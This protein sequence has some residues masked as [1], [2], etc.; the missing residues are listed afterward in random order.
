MPETA[1][2]PPSEFEVQTGVPA[3]RD[4]MAE[5]LGQPGLP[6]RMCYHNLQN[7]IWPGVHRGGKWQLRPYR[8]LEELRREEDEA[9]AARRARLAAAK[10][11]NGERL[12]LPEPPQ[13]KRPPRGRPRKTQRAAS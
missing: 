3:I 6:E 5:L 8:V 7:A 12:E 11:G 10:A 1:V 9:L 2:I 13:P 4:R